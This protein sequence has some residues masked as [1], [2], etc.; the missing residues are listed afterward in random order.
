MRRCGAH[1]AN[2][3]GSGKQCRWRRCGVRGAVC[4]GSGSSYLQIC[5]WTRQIAVSLEATEA[6]HFARL[7]AN[8]HSNAMRRNFSTTCS[9]N[10]TSAVGQPARDGQWC[11]FAGFGSHQYCCRLTTVDCCRVRLV[12]R[13][14]IVSPASLCVSLCTPTLVNPFLDER[15]VAVRKELNFL[16]Q[17]QH[18]ARD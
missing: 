10:S 1:F 7:Q 3:C 11:V 15:V 13:G 18:H 17:R 14:S 5:P 6:A 8:C 4:C 12:E 16:A 9:S 2:C